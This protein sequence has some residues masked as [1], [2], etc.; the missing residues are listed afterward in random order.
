MSQA[1]QQAVATFQAITE[2]ARATSAQI[3]AAFTSAVRSASSREDIAALGTSLQAA[4]DQGRI[5]LEAAERAGL[6]LQNRI[7]EIATAADPLGDA[8]G[9]LG[10]KSQQALNAA[11]D[12]AREAFQA[13]AD[14]AR[15]GQASQEDVIRSFEAYAAAAR[16][17]VAQS[18]QAVRDQVEA[19]L[20]TE[21]AVR[22]V[23][24]A[25][26]AMGDTGEDAA[27]RT[28]AA[29]DDSAAALGRLG[30]AADGAADS[31][32]GMGTQANNAAQGLQNVAKAGQEAAGIALDV[33]QA[34]ADAASSLNGL[35]QTRFALLTSEQRQANEY[36]ATLQQQL[37]A[38]DELA[39]RVNQLRGTY[40]QLGDAQLE[41]IARTEQQLE[42][43][44]K[45]AEDEKRSAR[46]QAQD[47]EREREG[48][49]T[50]TSS[51][52]APVSRVVVEVTGR[53]VDVNAVVNDSG[54]MRKLTEAVVGH[55][56]R[57]RSL[58]G[59]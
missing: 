52:S 13:I 17:A 55:I 45:R 51:G 22:G 54:A 42:Q 15:R 33:S 7:R 20:R 28:A 23:T 21:A 43:A 49:S 57:D 32:S 14:G 4:A 56:K 29:A 9:R 34:F 58:S 24:A 59:A 16:A 41:Q 8:F 40:T 5:S 1:G 36:L 46:E 19:H 18:T 44:R 2:N 39:Q 25:L 31:A 3:E 48:T 10:I 47:D 37:S 53:Y 11:R 6:A 50:T 27:T 35:D 26:D 12:S 38:Y 30:E